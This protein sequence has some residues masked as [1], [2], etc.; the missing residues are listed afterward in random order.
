MRNVNLDRINPK[1][2]DCVITYFKCF[3][4]FGKFATSKIYGA[5]KIRKNMYEISEAE[6]LA[7]YSAS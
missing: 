7:R 3:Y 1:I 4:I 5:S 6:H 2:A